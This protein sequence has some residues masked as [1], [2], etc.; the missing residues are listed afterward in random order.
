MKLSR[1][2][3]AE[4]NS[5]LNSQIPLIN[6]TMYVTPFSPCDRCAVHIIAAGIKKVVAEKSYDPKWEQEFKWAKEWFEEAGVELQFYT[7]PHHITNQ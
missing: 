5:L 7:L 1:T 2:I 3:H 6:T 4:M